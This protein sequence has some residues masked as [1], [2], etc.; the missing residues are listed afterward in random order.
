MMKMKLLHSLFISLSFSRSLFF[1]IHKKT[2]QKIYN[3]R[4]KNR[5]ISNNYFI[6]KI[7]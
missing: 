4:E 6:V 3:N 7:A 5:E 2:K 1:P